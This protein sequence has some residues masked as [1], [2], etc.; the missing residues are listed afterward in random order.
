[1]KIKDKVVIVTGASKGIGEW[2]CGLLYKEGS[3]IVAVSRTKAKIVDCINSSGGKAIWIKADVSNEKQ[4]ENVFKKAKKKF[5]GV[6]FLI[7]NAGVLFNH[8]K[9]P[10]EKTPS[11]EFDITMAI[12]LRGTWIGCKLAKRYIKKGIIVNASSVAGVPGHGEKYLSAY[13]AS[14]FGIMGLTESLNEEFKPKIKVYAIAPHSVATGMSRFEGNHPKDIAK[15]YIRVL[16]EKVSLKPGK[17][18][19]AGALNQVGKKKYYLKDKKAQET[20]EGCKN[21]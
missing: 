15:V 18:L 1:M 4:F 13:N 14:K 17:Y 8:P 16:K 6:D 21:F 20:F 2:I 9:K 7:N 19:I 3:K 5:G 10:I 11:K 12:N